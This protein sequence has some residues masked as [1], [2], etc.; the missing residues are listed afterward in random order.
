MNLFFF[1]KTLT[2]L[3]V[4]VFPCQSKGLIGGFTDDMMCADTFTGELDTFV[5]VEEFPVESS[6]ENFETLKKECQ[7]FYLT[8]DGYSCLTVGDLDG[9]F[10][11][12]YKKAEMDTFGKLMATEMGVTPR[13]AEIY[14]DSYQKGSASYG[15]YASG[16]S[17][18]YF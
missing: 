7:K 4:S 9:G 2:I 11:T 18:N 17:S 1:F 6:S 15:K 16:L 5:T 10:C 3:N 8:L 13:E 12:A 14:L